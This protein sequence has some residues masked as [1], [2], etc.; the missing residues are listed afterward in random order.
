L[1]RKKE[2]EKEERKMKGGLGNSWTGDPETLLQD[3]SDVK[4]PQNINMK[5]VA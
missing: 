2:R 5:K 4:I 3:C 1:R